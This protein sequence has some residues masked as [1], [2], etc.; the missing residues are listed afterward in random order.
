MNEIDGDAGSAVI[1]KNPHKRSV[2]IEVMDRALT[3]RP[4]GEQR[5]TMSKSRATGSAPWA[6]KSE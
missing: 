4:S 5:R 6:T 2:T 1:G 3:F